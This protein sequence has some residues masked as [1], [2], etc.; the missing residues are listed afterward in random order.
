VGLAHS[1]MRG[2]LQN[3]RGALPADLPATHSRCGC[4]AI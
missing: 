2:L 4:R 1:L 3:V